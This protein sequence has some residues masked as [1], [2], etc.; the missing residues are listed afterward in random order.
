MKSYSLFLNYLAGKIVNQITLNTYFDV[1]R[2]AIIFRHPKR[3]E[4]KNSFLEPFSTNVWLLTAA[5]GVL[6]WLLLYLTIRVEQRFIGKVGNIT[7]YTQPESET[8]LITSA[9]ICQQGNKIVNE[10]KKI[11]NKLNGKNLR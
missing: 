11:I 7:L 4:L 10:S 6:N 5:V 1:V 8:F 9:A 2:A 3:Q